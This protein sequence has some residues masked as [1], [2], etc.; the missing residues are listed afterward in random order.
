MFVCL[1][2]GSLDRDGALREANYVRDSKRTRMNVPPSDQS[3]PLILRI[4][5]YT[6]HNARNHL[7]CSFGTEDGDEESSESSSFFANSR[8][9][10][11]MVKP[12]SEFQHEF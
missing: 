9:D 7:D 12:N 4:S 6:H 8:K 2:V 11:F 1:C 3:Y 5:S 10:I